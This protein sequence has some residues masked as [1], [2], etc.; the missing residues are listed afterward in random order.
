LRATF[1][2]GFLV[3][4]L[5]FMAFRRPLAR[6]TVRIQNA[7]W[8]FRMSERSVRA[9]EWAYLVVGLGCL[10]FGAAALLGVGRF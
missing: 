4:G 5:A 10:V 3:V 1:G 9:G 8:G 6:E 2:V 7:T